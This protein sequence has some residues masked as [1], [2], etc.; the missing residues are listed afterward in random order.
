M[1]WSSTTSP[2]AGP[3]DRSRGAR[4]PRVQWTMRF[5]ASLLR[6]DR[7]RTVRRDSDAPAYPRS[8][9]LGGSRPRGKVPR[10]LRSSVPF[11]LFD[12]FRVP[13]RVDRTA[14]PP[15]LG[16]LWAEAD[17]SRALYWLPSAV[18]VDG[19]RSGAYRLERT[20]IFCAV[21]PDDGCQAVAFR[22]RRRV[23]SS[24]LDR[25]RRRS[26]CRLRV[27]RRSRTHLSSVRSGRGDRA[28]L[29]R[30]LSRVPRQLGDE[31]T[32]LGCP[33]VRITASARSSLAL[34]RSGRAAYSASS[35]RGRA[36]P[37]GRSRQR[38]TT[39]TISSSVSSSSSS[40]SR[41]R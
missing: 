23:A 10:L 19:R 7:L 8:S 11:L 36:S 1:T 4:R 2:P 12:Y 15:S 40:T 18:D 39:S 13:Y 17:E 32:S 35:R 21:L 28:I 24:E 30:A 31:G 38:C 22:T 5:I 26:A 37:A 29:E 20:P 16:R 25:R 33:A 9:F 34:G 14:D 27:A 3:I 6:D 41:S